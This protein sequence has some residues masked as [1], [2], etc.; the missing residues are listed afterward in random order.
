MDAELIAYSRQKSLFQ[1]LE[2]AANNISNQNTSGFKQELAVYMKADNKIDGARNPNPN[3]MLATNLS[4]GEFTATGRSLDVAIKGEGFFEVETPLGSRYT[5]A[6]SLQVN[7]EGVLTNT[8][9]YPV[10]G[11]GGSITL[12]P[13]DTDIIINDAG[14]IFSQTETGLEPRGTLGVVKFADQSALKKTGDN[15]FSNDG[16][17]EQALA[18]IDYKIAQGMLESSN[19]KGVQQMNELIEINRAVAQTAKIM[20]DQNQLVRTAVSRIIKSE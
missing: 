12:D 18:K 1:R 16:G 10:L 15:L 4:E 8:Q 14:E 11:D 2:V 19:V 3:M 9:G 17:S 5:R 13:N 6:G 20:T 7:N